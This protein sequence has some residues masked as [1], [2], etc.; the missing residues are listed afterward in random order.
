MVKRINNSEAMDRFRINPIIILVILL[1]LLV[2]TRSVRRARRIMNL[3]NRE[4]MEDIADSRGRIEGFKMFSSL[5]NT[6]NGDVKPLSH[7]AKNVRTVKVK[8]EVTENSLTSSS[9]YPDLKMEALKSPSEIRDLDDT[10]MSYIKIKKS[11]ISISECSR[12]LGIPSSE[13]KKTLVRLHETGR[14]KLQWGI[15]HD[16]RLVQSKHSK[17]Y[18]NSL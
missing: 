18:S 9:E 1:I 16:V 3:I 5:N 8:S 7:I 11:R 12:D 2:T 6:L 14:I 17:T 15:E 13:V 10:L 4:F